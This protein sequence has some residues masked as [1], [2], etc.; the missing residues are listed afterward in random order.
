MLWGALLHSKH[1]YTTA[2]SLSIPTSVPACPRLLICCLQ[3]G[4]SR[5]MLIICCSP[6]S[7]NGPETLSSL[8]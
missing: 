6:C 8:R 2:F 5:T 1:I 7:E 3:G 4:T